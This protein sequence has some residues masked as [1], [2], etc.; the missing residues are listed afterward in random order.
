MK[1]GASFGL[2]SRR[3]FLK[4]MGA[5]G[6][7]LLYPQAWSALLSERA[8]GA[9]AKMGKKITLLNAGDFQGS[10]WGWQFT[11]GASIMAA[12][13][14]S[15]RNAAGIRTNSGDYARFLVLGPEQGKTY[16]LSGWVRTESVVAEEDG[17][18]AYFGASQYEFQGRPTEFTVDGKQ[19]PE[20]RYGNWT[21]STDWQ[22]FSRSF[23]CLETTTW[24][25]VVIGIYRASGRA[26]FSDLTFVEGDQPVAFEDAVDY[27]QAEQWAHEAQIGE[28]RSGIPSAAIL[29]DNIPVRGT[30]SD[31]LILARD[32]KE[33]HH[34]EFVDADALG[35][36]QRF[37]RDKFD[38]LVLPYGE[39]FPL[40]AWKTVRA[41]LAN[42]GDLLTTGGYAFQSP[43]VKKSGGWIFYDEEVAHESG[44]NLLPEIDSGNWK[45]SDRSRVRTVAATLPGMGAQRAVRIEVPAN[46]WEQ[47]ESWAVDLA[48]SGDGEQFYFECWMRTDEVQAAP[49][50]D[51]FVGVEQLD[52]EGYPAYAARVTF[53][54]VRGTSDWQK[55]SRLFYL[56]PTCRKLR[57]RIG[58]KNAT[59][60]VWG[61]GFRLEHRSP[62][63]R[64]N[65]AHGF[66]EDSLNVSPKQIG[67]FDP[68]FRLRRVE[69]VR[70]AKG[71]AILP[72]DAGEVTGKFEGYAASAVVG[73]NNARWIP[74]LQAQDGVGRKRGAA[75]ALVHNARGTYARGSWAFFGVENRDLFAAE[76]KLGR[77]TLR[78][79]GRV[80][81]RKCFLH[82][83]D[84]KYAAYREG[85]EVGLRVLASNY[86]R[87]EQ[88][89]K[90]RWQIFP[91]DGGP[92]E[93][94]RTEPLHLAPGQTA[95]AEMA[96]NPASFSSDRYRVQATLFAGQTEI[97][98]IET[99]FDIWNN[100]TLQ[101]GLAFEFRDNYFQVDG[102]S[103]FLQGTDDYL[104]TFIDQDENPL[105]W[106]EDA[107]GCRDSCIDVYE[108]LMGLRG[109]QQRPT[110]TW[111]RWIDA[112]LL[113]VQRVGGAFFPGM[114]VFSNT[115]VS[116]TDMAD[117]QAYV[118]AFADR[119]KDA[120][121][122]MYY[123]NGDL[124]LHDPNLPDLQKL[125]HEYLK[126][127]YGSDDVLR[128]AWKISPPEAPI[129]KLTIRR[130]SDDWADVRTVDDFRFR[131]QVVRR[132][133]N[134]MHDAIREADAR[135]PVTAEFYQRPVSGIDLL[136]AL[137]KLELANFGYFN[138]KNED[139]YRF[140]QT[141]K[142][143]DQSMRGKG[144]NVG[145]F[146]VKTHPAWNDTGYYI[147][148][149]TEEYEHAYFLAI[150]HY[151]FAL[152]AS[153]IQNWCW[154]Y[155]A[156]LPFEWGINYPN[157]LVPRDV[158]A[159]YRNTGLLFRRLR[160]SYHPSETLVLLAG[161]NRMGGRGSS[162]V[163]GQL[164]CIRLLLD[165][166]L[167]FATLADDY[168]ESLHE[169]VKT[170][171]YPLPYCPSD[172]IITRLE[173]FVDRGGQL[174][175]SGDLSY[176]S[177]RQ[178]TRV[179]RLRDLCG[180]EFVS[181]RFR[182]IEYQ[183]GALRTVPDDGNWPAYMA[184]PGIVTR[185]AGARVLLKGENGAP[186]VTEFRRGRG[187]VI[188]SADPIELHGDP[189]YQ[190]YAH[191]FYSA[192]LKT[193]ELDGEIIE[194]ADAPVH[195]FRV[196]AQDARD[197]K[198]LVNYDSD[199]PVR[200]ISVPSAGNHVRLTLGPWMSG[201]VVS[202]QGK[203][204]QLV[205][206]SGNAYEGD[207][208]VIGS[209]L[210]VMA[211]SIGDDSLL[212]S[213][214]ILVLPMGQGEL[215]IPNAA[216]WKDPV[217]VVGEVT[218]SRWRELERLPLAASDGQINI[219]IHADRTL[220]MLV[221]CEA[222]ERTMAVERVESWHS[223]PW[224]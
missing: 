150:A 142:F 43:I 135:H 47:N 160:P 55:V 186:V 70:P 169:S 207:R 91:S 196:P 49:D 98:Q 209:D 58:L 145:E 29:R 113:N 52:G 19:M 23:K 109:P 15:G 1:A 129:G 87:R 151:G 137:D 59:G 176:D 215:R 17:A 220:S 191:E 86:G 104:H 73:M 189:R 122:I 9:A 224:R 96:W 118:R 77:E 12:P 140:P 213:R 40:A 33:T 78:A 138:E 114:L 159:F 180:L 195:C 178:R 203:G 16:T 42:G 166:R 63:V 21:G 3:G 14:R 181:E 71:Q 111:W 175:M 72:V 4:G 81:A 146:G 148:A 51:A 192:L 48:A 131:T 35:D 112:M 83:C 162:I 13:G 134:A 130:G 141:C 30:A 18:G 57:V 103:V 222:A 94:D 197:V 170:I 53:A 212:D 201:V 128:S 221:L 153:K 108:N 155:P 26:W 66:P 110:E 101:K 82:D 88:S 60:A 36:A 143:L 62:Q 206:T 10:C 187:R 95:K 116:D 85:E 117:Q 136:L 25:E 205:E 193:L 204:I 173:E 69:V 165:Q 190:S 46:L 106:F 39:S 120:A 20:Q 161:D 157:D 37:N 38:L 139:F 99:G 84:T 64:I 126:A 7:A 67:M 182:N 50:G 115:A 121:G 54:E 100:G 217:A 61:T 124:E 211:I 107:Q 132:W 102:K 172:A 2:Q 208:L 45:A 44:P 199:K 210:H 214:S 218:G 56:T 168:L 27:W 167:R 31:P 133:L 5:T 28:E 80:F 105:T 89:L 11:G 8:R 216:R 171:F 32:L 163:E 22:R 158:R 90:L 202:A 152:G 127:K 223:T 147:E 97:D 149:R 125:Y 6:A 184:A 174:Y 156:D 24:F 164:N 119:Y 93:L 177:L 41:F 154:K 194:P 75:G 219:P 34:V 74:L 68:D 65:T 200:D 198:V 185:S 76:S 79:V 144:I 92:S 188:F 179:D 183:R 123:L